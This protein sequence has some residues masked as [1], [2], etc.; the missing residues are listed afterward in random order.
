MPRRTSPVYRELARAACSFSRTIHA[1]WAALLAQSEIRDG[2]YLTGVV[3]WSGAQFMIGRF[4]FA[5]GRPSAG[6][7]QWGSMTDA[8]APLPDEKRVFV[9]PNPFLTTAELLIVAPKASD[10]R[11]EIFDPAGRRVRDWSERLR[12]GVSS[13]HWDGRDDG[14][15]TVA[16]GSY[17]VRV[18]TSEWESAAR[19]VRLRKEP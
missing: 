9:Q 2:G 14:G 3:E 8:A 16:Q 18:S 12:A 15:L 5:G 13:L 17:W 11:I 4:D 10:A 1:F 19:V 7:A 6:F